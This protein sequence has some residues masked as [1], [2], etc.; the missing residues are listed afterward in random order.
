[1][2]KNI[3]I[4]LVL[5]VAIIG[6]AIYFVSDKTAVPEIDDLSQSQNI[7]IR[8]DIQYITINAR[9]GYSPRISVAQPNIPTKLVVKTNETFDCSASLTIRDV[10]F[11]KVLQPTGEETIDLGIL[12]EGGTI[13]GVC[14]MGMY[15][16]QI[17][18]T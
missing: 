6:G 13:Q 17:R 4:S 2:K 16:F 9:G 3:A 5:S 7:E 11:Q 10:G 8:D 15:S 14:S 18:S 12:K 1:M